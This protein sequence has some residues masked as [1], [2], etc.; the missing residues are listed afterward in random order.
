MKSKVSVYMGRN[1][2]DEIHIELTCETSGHR[3][4]DVRVPAEQFGLMVTGRFVTI[5]PELKHL[6]RI[7]KKRIS[8]RRSI[9]VPGRMGRDLAEDW[10][11]ENAKEEGWFVDSYLGGQTS[12]EYISSDEQKLNYRV[13]KYVEIEE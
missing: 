12:M 13:Y 7:G 10:L 1:N 6:D 3:F 11:E 2:H 4:F 9:V 5:E 8:E